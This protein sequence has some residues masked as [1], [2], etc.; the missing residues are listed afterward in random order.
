[1]AGKSV[2]VIGA[3]IQ[4]HWSDSVSTNFGLLVHGFPNLLLVNGPQS[5][6]VHFSPPQ[7]PNI[8]LTSF[9]GLSV[10]AETEPL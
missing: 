1:M 3:R 6:A 9:R 2:G 10:L 4:D 7:L 5:P 8:R